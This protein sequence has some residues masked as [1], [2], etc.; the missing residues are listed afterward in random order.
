MQFR[1]SSD[2]FLV[3]LFIYLQYAVNVTDGVC[4][5]AI[6]TV[7][8]RMRQ[9]ITSAVRDFRSA[10]CKPSYF[11]AACCSFDLEMHFLWQ[12][13]EMSEN[14]SLGTV[15]QHVESALCTLL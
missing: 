4:F 7:T 13:I 14:G 2:R 15:R 8:G 10:A 9:H 11:V 6:E 12:A 5:S 3:Y 1:Q